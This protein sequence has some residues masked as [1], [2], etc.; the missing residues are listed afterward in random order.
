MS[1]RLDRNKGFTA[2]T[3]G[4]RG[5]QL[6]DKKNVCESMVYLQSH[7]QRPKP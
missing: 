7:T 3:R 5:M 1:C 6:G 4:C 2:C